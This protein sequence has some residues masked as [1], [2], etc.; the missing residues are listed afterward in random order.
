M[1]RDQKEWLFNT[2]LIL[3]IAVLIALI[4]MQRFSRPQLAPPLESISAD[5]GVEDPDSQGQQPAEQGLSGEKTFRHLGASDPF[6]PIYTPAPPPPTRTPRPEPTPNLERATNGW[7]LQYPFR[8]TGQPTMWVFEGAKKEEYQ[9]PE[10][11]PFSLTDG[12]QTF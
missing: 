12:R 6:S 7:T 2:V 10:G 9:I 11:V 3:A 5:P 4:G 8:R 1:R